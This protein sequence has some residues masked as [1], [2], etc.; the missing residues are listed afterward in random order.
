MAEKR[1]SGAAAP[2][3]VPVGTASKKPVELPN[4]LHPAAMSALDAVISLQ[5]KSVVGDERAMAWSEQ[6]GGPRRTEV[7]SGMLRRLDANYRNVTSILDVMADNEL[8]VLGDVNQHQPVRNSGYVDVSYA[9]LT[10]SIVTDFYHKVFL[11]ALAYEILSK[12]CD[13]D[14]SED[15]VAREWSEYKSRVAE[16]PAIEYDE[17]QTHLL[18]EWRRFWK[19]T[20]RLGDTPAG[21]NKGGRPSTVEESKKIAKRWDAGEWETHRKLLTF[22]KSDTEFNGVFRVNDTDGV[23]RILDRGGAQR[24]KQHKAT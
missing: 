17:L 18:C 12:P 22:L 15:G 23:R 24:R 20:G 11:G 5:S 1:K 2:N 13:L 3:S 21:R 6:H 4:E 19:A 16:F 14:F 10:C 9:Q 8:I 7:A